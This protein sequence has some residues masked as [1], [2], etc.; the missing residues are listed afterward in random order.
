MLRQVDENRYPVI[1]E[2]E[3]RVTEFIAPEFR[4]FAAGLVDPGQPRG[5]SS[6]TASRRPR[7]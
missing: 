2:L 4:I 7:A 5:A 1:S 6:G 3:R